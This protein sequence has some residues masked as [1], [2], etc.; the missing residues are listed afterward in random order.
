MRTESSTFLVWFERLP[1][2]HY[3]QLLDGAAEIAGSPGTVPEDP[4]AAVADADAIIASSRL[5]YDAELMDRAPRLRVISRT[6]M[7]LDNISIADATARRI[8]VCN[9]PG[10]PTVSTAEHTLALI[11]AVTKRLKQ[12][13][14][15]LREGGQDYFNDYDGIELC[16]LA[17]G[18][19]GLGQIGSRVAAFGRALGMRVLAFDPYVDSR[20]AAEQGVELVHTLEALLAVCDVV[21]LHA[22]LTPETY[23]LMDASRLALMKPGAVLVNTARGR[24][25]DE[26][27]LL[28]ALEQ[29]HL[30]GAGLD[31]F[32]P[33]PPDP[34]STLLSREDV[35][36]TPHI[37]GATRASKDRLWRTA[38]TQA[39]QV[40]RGERP[41]HLVNVEV[42]VQDDR[43][44]S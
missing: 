18:L 44:P 10:G 19:V 31:V 13:Q 37:A 21:S 7:G 3:A 40:L 28:D 41:L 29:G 6:G 4:F 42:W 22:P 11:L 5:R 33:E 23:Q 20:C 8:A 24:L 17:L 30:G 34:V 38:I 14:Q 26:R 12:S 39:L 15:A 43:A 32:D 25:V 2:P 16:G 36:A 27:A 1:P 35:V 9:V